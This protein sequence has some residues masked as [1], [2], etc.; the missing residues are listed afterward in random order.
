VLRLAGATVAGGYH[1]RVQQPTAIETSPCPFIGLVE[2]QRTRFAFPSP[3]HRCFAKPRR[4]VTIDSS[5]QSSFCLV[6]AH[7]RCSRYRG[8]DLRP[9]EPEQLRD[10]I[11]D[12]LAAAGAVTPRVSNRIRRRAVTAILIVVLGFSAAFLG[13]T[14]WYVIH[15]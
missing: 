10:P 9:P 8:S 4:P 13:A 3:A 5:F 6:D 11:R 15:A 7:L 14:L 12:Q 1:P 2:D